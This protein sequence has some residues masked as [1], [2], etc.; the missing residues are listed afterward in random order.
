M[1]ELNVFSMFAGVGGFEVGLSKADKDYYRVLY[2]NQF[3]PSRKS[4]D[5]LDVLNYR[6]P[7]VETIGIDIAEVSDEKFREMR[8]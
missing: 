7:D 3:E 5:A 4:Q 1:S 2:Q 8:K 6:F